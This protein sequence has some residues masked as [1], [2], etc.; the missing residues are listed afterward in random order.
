MTDT[1]DPRVARPKHI[2]ARIPRTEDARLLTGRGRFVDDREPGG[3]LHVAFRRSD[4]AH[5][6]IRAVD[7]SAARDMP[8]V[9]AVLTAA[10]LEGG[11]VPLSAQSRMKSYYATPLLAL[12]KGKVRYAGEPV[13]A[14]IATSRYLAEDAAALI[15]ID[16]DLLAPL[17]D[18]EA[19]ARS[20]AVL[21][22]E[23]AGTNVIVSREFRR[24]EVE[25]R[26]AQATVRVGGRFR[27]R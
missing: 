16:L 5:A 24:G 4:H 25:V 11:L 14:V 12:A 22:H 1:L 19:A 7:T 20:G 21:L 26:M 9:V 18:P 6:T 27:I 15:T 10:D 8:G 2:G 3:L 23:V 17:V 13:A